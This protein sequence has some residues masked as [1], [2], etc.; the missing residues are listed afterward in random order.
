MEEKDSIPT[1]QGKEIQINPVIVLEPRGQ[2]F[3]IWK[4][5]SVI[6]KRIE[7]NTDDRSQDIKTTISKKADNK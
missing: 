6:L 5:T 1:E 4:P 7:V 2:R 3:V